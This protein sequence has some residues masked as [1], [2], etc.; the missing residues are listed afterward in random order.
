VRE[1]AKEKVLSHF[2]VN[3]HQK[4]IKQ[5]EI[6]LDSFVPS[7]K[8]GNVSNSN[9]NQY[10]KHYVDQQWDQLKQRMGGVVRAPRGGLNR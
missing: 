6:K 9:D 5:G 8:N 10:I 7:L 1:E 3:R 2:T 4:I